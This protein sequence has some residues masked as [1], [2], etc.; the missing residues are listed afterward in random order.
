MSLPFA[1]HLHIS[2]PVVI[3]SLEQRKATKGLAIHIDDP[4]QS[5]SPGDIITGRAFRQVPVLIGADSVKIT[6]RLVGR[7]TTKT[8]VWSDHL[9]ESQRSHTTR[10]DVLDPDE[11]LLTLNDGPLHISRTD[12]SLADDELDS[13]GYDEDVGES[14]PFTI[15]IPS[16]A[17]PSW[18][19]KPGED[20]VCRLPASSYARRTEI[21]PGEF[22]SSHVQYFL[23]ARLVSAHS[24]NYPVAVELITIDGED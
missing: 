14:W 13:R 3:M 22:R 9:G 1:V 23:E 7:S 2:S 6:I 12:N 19:R 10:T 11:S 20:K 15:V 21:A 17:S 5:Y 16:Y 18:G 8:T 4:Q 24:N